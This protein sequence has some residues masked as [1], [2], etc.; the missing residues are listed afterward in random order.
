MIIFFL[1]FYFHKYIAISNGDMAIA[2]YNYD[3]CQRFCIERC[4][5]SEGYGTQLTRDMFLPSADSKAVCRMPNAECL[6][7]TLTKKSY[8]THL[9]SMRID[10]HSIFLRFFCGIVR[11]CF[12]IL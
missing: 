9:R 4:F 10:I 8:E 2:S 7:S 5:L 1:F 12:R 3:K 6:E 11:T